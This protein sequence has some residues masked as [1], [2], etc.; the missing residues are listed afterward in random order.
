VPA[1]PARGFFHLSRAQ[2]A[3]EV[4]AGEDVVHAQAFGTGKALAHVALKQVPVVD[5]VLA[6]SVLE[7]VRRDGHLARLAADR[8]FHRRPK[9]ASALEYGGD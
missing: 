1:A 5:D 3:E 7:P 6:S 9:K 8:W 4:V 2:V